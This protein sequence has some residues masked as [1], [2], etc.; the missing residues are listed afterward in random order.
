MS[1]HMNAQGVTVGFGTSNFTAEVLGVTPPNLS[2]PDI[3]VTHLGTTKFKA[4]EPG[5]L[6]DGGECT[7]R[8]AY[9]PSDVPPIRGVAEVITITMPDSGATAV[10]FSGYCKGFAPGEM[11]EDSRVEATMTLK[12]AGEVSIDG[13]IIGD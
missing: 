9:F 3:D 1:G 13:T 11:T 6:V 4:F 5:D 10:T 2:R 8:I 12:V 7:L